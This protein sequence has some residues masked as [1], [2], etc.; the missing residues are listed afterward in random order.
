MLDLPTS[1]IPARKLLDQYRQIRT[2]SVRLCEPLE[3]EDMTIQPITD[4][5][6]PKWHLGHTTWFF[7]NFILIPL[8]PEYRAFDKQL[9]WFFNSYYESQ[10]PRIHRSNRGNMS[11]PTTATI[12]EYRAYVD[13]FMAQLESRALP[14]VS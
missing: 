7:E 10:G 5:S 14:P 1:T 9:H 13:Q 3:A 4:V 11:R 8:L 6:P 2:Q 12:L